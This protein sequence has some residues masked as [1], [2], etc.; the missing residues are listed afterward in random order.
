M[1]RDNR[2]RIPGPLEESLR[3]LPQ[4][5]RRHMENLWMKLPEYGPSDDAPDVDS[6]WRELEARLDANEAARTLSEASPRELTLNSSET[7]RRSTDAGRIYTDAERR[8]RGAIR[9]ETRR[10]HSLTA[11]LAIGAVS[12]AA[13]L[14]VSIWL[15]NR[16][17]TIEVAAGQHRDVHLADGSIVEINSDTR[18]EVSGSLRNNLAVRGAVRRV[19]LDG[20]AYFQVA[21]SEQPFI[22]ETPDAVVRVTGTEFN[23]RARPDERGTSTSVTLVSGSVEIMA[24]SAPDGESNLKPVILDIPGAS[25]R[26]G[27]AHAVRL[28]HPDDGPALDHVLAWRRRGFAFTDTPISGIL[29]EVERRFGV[30][31]TPREGVHLAEPMNLFYSRGVTPEEILNDIC[32]EQS[33]RYRPT[34]RGFALEEDYRTPALP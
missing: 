14:V 13:L 24:K 27:G 26:V 20:E 19:R 25:A 22:V 21:R 3:K 7:T 18:L 16:P 29:D 2:G 15:M 9:L 8:D 28:L 34:S 1:S 11:K 17:A 32:F 30:E 5:K 23:I 4:D 31:I 33:C 12:I 6:A 10:R